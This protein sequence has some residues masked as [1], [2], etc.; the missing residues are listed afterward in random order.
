MTKLGESRE[1]GRYARNPVAGERLEQET[2]KGRT[3]AVLS[4][5]FAFVPVSRLN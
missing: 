2:E 1:I 3:D 5:I 4:V